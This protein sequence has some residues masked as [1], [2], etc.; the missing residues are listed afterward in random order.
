MRQIEEARAWEL[1]DCV[2]AFQTKGILLPIGA[3]LLVCSAWPSSA[4]TDSAHLIVRNS[5]GAPTVSRNQLLAPDKAVRAIQRARKDIVDGQLESAQKEITRALDLAPHFAV[6]KFM[7]RAI[8][9]TADNYASAAT[10]FQEAI[11]E[12]PALGGAYVGMAV[13]LIH[14]QRLQAALPQLDR[15]EGLLPGV[16]FVRFA[17]AWAQ[18]GLGNTEAALKQAQLAERIAG[19]DAEKRSGVSYL[20]V[21]VCIHLNDVASGRE[22]LAEA[23]ERDRD[24]QYAALASKEM[25]RLQPL[26]VAGR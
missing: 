13:V 4:Q 25:E 3:L 7:H 11:D 12:D 20:R 10:L 8:D 24:G 5:S 6:A 19:A 14:E 1:S 9:I 26:L 21:M 15:A 23:V 16:W 17:K 22:Y 18:L 2:P